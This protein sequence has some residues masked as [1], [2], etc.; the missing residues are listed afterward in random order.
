MEMESGGGFAS[1]PFGRERGKLE[2]PVVLGVMM[3][4]SR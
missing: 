4:L 3:S 2:G 1:I